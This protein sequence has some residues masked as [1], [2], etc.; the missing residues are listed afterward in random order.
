MPLAPQLWLAV[1]A[2]ALVRPGA[3]T[4]GAS[5]L[6][7]VRARAAIRS[8]SYAESADAKSDVFC[9][10]AIQRAHNDAYAGLPLVAM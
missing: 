6:R 7:R 2:T 9:P 3:P 10:E 5:A 8:A 1:L 4:V